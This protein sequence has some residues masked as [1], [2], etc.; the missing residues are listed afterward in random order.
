MALLSTYQKF[1]EKNTHGGQSEPQKQETQKEN[2][3][4][5]LMSTYQQFMSK[6]QGGTQAV[7]PAQD[8]NQRVWD[9]LQRVDSVNANRNG[10]WRWERPGNQRATAG[11]RCL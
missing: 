1:K 10:A 3:G 2:S 9:V 4:S 6:K 5:G 11:V 7:S 8:Y